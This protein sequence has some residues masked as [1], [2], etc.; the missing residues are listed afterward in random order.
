MSVVVGRAGVGDSACSLLTNKLAEAVARLVPGSGSRCLDDSGD[1][2]GAG[3]MLRVFAVEAS[4]LG[5]V[6]VEAAAQHEAQPGLQE[7]EVL[8]RTQIRGQP[9]YCPAQG[10]IGLRDACMR[11]ANSC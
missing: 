1:G 9:A 10:S 8:E 5:E 11:H 4:S 6:G 7:P 3:N 2:G